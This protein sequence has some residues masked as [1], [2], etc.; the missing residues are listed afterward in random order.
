VLLDCSVFF[1]G[2]AAALPAYVMNRKALS[3]LYDELNGKVF[4]SS[5]LALLN[6]R[7]GK[8]ALAYFYLIAC[9]GTF[10]ANILRSSPLIG[11]EEFF[12]FGGYLSAHVLPFV[13]PPKP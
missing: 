2:A 4:L 11:A 8:N 13:F 3:E 6:S 9:A 5:Q 12:L 1:L 7:Q 10:L